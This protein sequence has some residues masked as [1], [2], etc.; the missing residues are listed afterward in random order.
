MLIGTNA[1]S[2]AGFGVSAHPPSRPC[3]RRHPFPFGFA[4][5][6]CIN[7]SNTTR[8]QQIAMANYAVSAKDAAIIMTLVFNALLFG[9]QDW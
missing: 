9:R 2:W 4:S 5:S 8:I 7:R 1:T 6:V 3:H